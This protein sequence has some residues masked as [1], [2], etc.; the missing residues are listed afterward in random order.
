[1]TWRE[2]VRGSAS[3]CGW[4]G[5]VLG[6]GGSGIVKVRVYSGKGEREQQSL[7]VKT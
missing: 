4:E 5:M 3:A 6:K 2:K 1:M 7:F